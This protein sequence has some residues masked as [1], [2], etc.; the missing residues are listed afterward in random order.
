MIFS[1][2]SYLWSVCSSWRLGQV[3]TI[4]SFHQNSDSKD[5]AG[6]SI[7]IYLN[8]IH[9]KSINFQLDLGKVGIVSLL[10]KSSIRTDV[11]PAEHDGEENAYNNCGLS[12][13]LL[14]FLK[15][16]I[17]GNYGKTC[18]V[19]WIFP[20]PKL[21]QIGVRG[22]KTV[23]GQRNCVLCKLNGGIPSNIQL[24]PRRRPPLCLMNNSVVKYVT[25]VL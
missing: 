3:K 10:N 21:F 1:S 18:P 23:S 11:K 20:R 25:K 22:M 4:K 13:L 17:A 5:S 15:C 19:F 12:D 14:H 24:K 9:R 6:C 8:F 7:L 2:E 16:L